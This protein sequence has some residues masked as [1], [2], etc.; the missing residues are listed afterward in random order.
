M[1]HEPLLTGDRNEVLR[2]IRHVRNRWRLR[3]GLR[4]VAVLVAAA[5]GTLLA[6]SFGLELFRF[7]P[8]AIVAFRVVTYMALLAFG[9]WLF[10]RPISRRVSD[11]R[12]ALYIEEHA[13]EL[14]ATVLSA[15]EESRKGKRERAAD[16][17]PELVR[18]LIESAVKQIREIDMGR[19]VETGQLWRSTG[20]LA[21]AGAAA[22]LLFTF[23]P[24]Y[25][26]HGI[27]ALL[28]PMGNVEAASPY[29]IEVLPGDA[30]VARG[31]DQAITAR[32]VGFEA[33]EVN[34]LMQGSGDSFDRLPLIPVLTEDGTTEAGQFEVLLFDLQEP[35]DYFVESIGVESATY[36]LDV[37]ELPYA[38]RI[39]LEYHFPEY[40]G[41][42]PR[43]VDDG[44]DIAVLQG[45]E[46]R[47]RAVPTMGT[48]GGQL[49]FDDD[50]DQRVDLTLEDDG[51]LTASFMV[52]EEGFYRVD[53]VAPAG[54]LVTASP[55][56]TID[57]LTDQPPSAM[58]IRP[59]RDT[60]ASAIEE[61]FVEA[62]ADDDFGLHSLD[63]VYS[64]NGGPEE[65][66][67]L[68]DGGGNA[69]RE[70]SAGHTFF[71]EELELEPG[72]FLSYYARAT[73]RNLLQQ[74]ADVKSD[75][76]FI[77]IRRYS[78]D[79]RMQA[80]QGGGGGGMG[81][82][83]DARELSKA[84]REIIS[85][86]F[87][88]VRDQEQYD[89]EEFEENVVFL[90]L[91]QGRLREQVETLVRRMN[92]RVMPA[93]PAFR[94]IQEI[95]PRAAEAMREA[96]NEL[97]EQDADGA[98]PPEQRALQHL[99]RAEEA[100]EE[101]MVT[102]GGGGGGGGGGGRQAAED[103]AD[104]FELELDKM[105]NQYETLE[106]AGQERA[107][108]TID[109]LMERLRELAR[110]QEREAERQRRRARGQQSTQGGG[111]GQRAL[112]EEAE[113]A[114]RRLERL[115]REQ[116]SPQMMDTARRLQE[117]ADAMRRAAAND[118]NLG[119]AEAGTA[120][121]RLREV[122]ER[123]S[124]EQRGR[125]ERDIADQLR[126]ANRLADQQ[127][128]MRGEVEQLPGLQDEERFTALRRLLEQ[129]G[130]M[131][132]E[133]ADLE[134][135]ID[136]TSAEFRRDERDASRELQEA[137]GGIRDNKL[138]EKIRYTRGLIR[139]RPGPTANAFE[140]QIGDNI[141]QLAEDLAEAAAAVGK[142]EGDRMAQALDRTRDL[143]RS[144][145]SLDHRMW[146]QGRQ[147]EDGEQGQEGQQGQAGQEGQG[148]EGQQGQAGQEGQQGQGGQEGQQGGQQ[149]QEG[150][151]GGQLGGADGWRGGDAS[152]FGRDWGGGYGDR[153]PG[154][155]VW[156][157]G[158]IRQW[159][160][161]YEQRA[162]EA[163]ELRRLLNE[164]DFE[165]GDLD[166]IIQRMRE[167]DDLRRY[168]DA[169]E[170]ASLQSFVLEELKRFEYR[171]RREI[172]EE[173]E[174]LFL[175]GNEEMPDEF[176]DLVEE[177]FRSLAQ[178]Q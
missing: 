44:G 77:Q 141:E 50:D 99:Q 68:F 126:R 81:G 172:T 150:Q 39:E 1:V 165:V 33:E 87:N 5:L 106:R 166:A 60:T 153:R 154:T 57:V 96:E 152:N 54:Q 89:A 117:A 80:S 143:M 32:L 92:S 137:A 40:T 111:A 42:E 98:L 49:V 168:Q 12:V 6:S 55:Q 148:Q 66:V 53:L 178:D 8:G 134:R 145:E 156:E 25:L 84:Q 171:L 101:V 116:N 162:G 52:E 58:F 161:E 157:P 85:A 121:D 28:T 115:A 97:Q 110:R 22:A 109:E 64:V 135:Q 163:Q 103:L 122:Q 34:L 16:H 93:D 131:E 27:N 146:Q 94:S 177:Y 36:R 46:V 56:Y 90:T 119:F 108:E 95:L 124:G 61:V 43:T 123:L 79:Y 29:Q 138:K 132:E 86:T 37:I 21:A 67:T 176:R 139:S 62:R 128:E 41:L 31:A 76:Y 107:D 63:L 30:T 91:A 136:S 169:E 105:R 3:L 174:D 142:S 73:D 118:D 19:R 35:V 144:L 147:G 23:G 9:W 159:S 83:A 13:P 130:Q 14:Q 78:Q 47:L 72:D 120:L 151:A 114:A 175:A 158:D 140:E 104:L 127:R 70:V 164:Q 20:L 74:D 125:L 71:F 2:A 75:L 65:S 167:L 149:G 102:M 129:K 69:L 160:R 48:T 59:G 100:Y 155:T 11:Q 45:T 170:I 133:V 38:E 51:T 24:A 4:G 7:D 173:N 82:G 26:R 18:R 17:S 15:V 113:E 112:A 10:I 88:L